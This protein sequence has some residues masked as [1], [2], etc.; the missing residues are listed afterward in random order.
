MEEPVSEDLL[1]V[2]ACEHL[3]HGRTWDPAC[4]ES[5]D[6]VDRDRIEVAHREHPGGRE[7]GQDRR[8]RDLGIVSE[9]SGDLACDVS[10]A[11]EVEFFDQASPEL[12]EEGRLVGNLAAAPRGDPVQTEAEQRKITR[13]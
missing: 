10:L 13:E 6:I 7:R 1:R 5:G 9:V 4:I 2:G 11:L 8:H 3:E 12:V